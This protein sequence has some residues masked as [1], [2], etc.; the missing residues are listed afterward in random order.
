MTDKS[1]GI[2]PGHVMKLKYRLAGWLITRYLCY[3]PGFDHHT[4]VI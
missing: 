1:G 3:F 4:M 2:L